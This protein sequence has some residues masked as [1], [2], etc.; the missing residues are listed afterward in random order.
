MNRTLQDKSPQKPS[1]YI[2]RKISTILSDKLY[3]INS[4][5]ILLELNPK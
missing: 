5:I 1:D 4:I 2:F 3:F